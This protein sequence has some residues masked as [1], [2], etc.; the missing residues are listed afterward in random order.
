MSYI[1]SVRL[2]D[3]K[4]RGSSKGFVVLN[5]VNQIRKYEA[6]TPTTSDGQKRTMLENAVSMISDFVL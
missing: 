2:G 1:T 4:W 5:W 6:I 3:G